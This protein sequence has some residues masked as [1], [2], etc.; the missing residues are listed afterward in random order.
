MT[1]KAIAPIALITALLIFGMKNESDLKGNE[2][3]E[4]VLMKLIVQGL[5]SSH[6]VD[7]KL[8]DSFSGQVYDLYLERMDFNKRFLLAEDIALFEKQRNLIDD[9]INA[10]TYAFFDLSSERIAKRVLEAE[11]YY[12]D[13]LSKPFDFSKDEQFE[14]DAEK[15]GWAVDKKEMKERWRQ[16]LK[17][18]TMTTLASLIEEQEKA[19]EKASEKG[20]KFVEK[21]FKELEKEAREKTAKN[22]DSWFKRLE[23]VT[24]TD[25]RTIFLNTITNVYDPHTSYLPPND[26]E[27]FDI[28]MSGRLEG[29]GATLQEK[30]GYIKVTA[31]VPGSA[32]WRQGELKEDD[33][34]LKVAQGQDEPV[35]IVDMPLDEAVQLIRGKKGTE[36]RLTVKKVSGDI[37]VIP[38]IRDIVILEETYAKSVFIQQEGGAK[39]IGYIKLPKFYADFSKNGGRNCSD[40]VKDELTKLMANDVHG[41]IID[42]RNNGGGSLDDVVKMTGLFIDQGP[43]VQVKGRFGKPYVLED[44][45]KGVYYDGPLVILVNSFSASASE[46]M[47]A[48]IQDYDR[49]IVMGSASTF[50]KGTV[51]RFVDLDRMIRDGFDEIKPLG[52]IKMTTQKFYRIDGGAT[53]NKGVIPDIIMPD[54]YR[55]IE[56]GEKEQDYALPWDEIEAVP[57]KNWQASGFDKN[58]V[59]LSGQQRVDDNEIFDVINNYAQNLKSQRD[60]TSYS[61]NLEQYRKEQ[62]QLKE[63]SEAYKKHFENVL[64]V[65]IT[66]LPQDEMGM[67]SDTLKQELAKKWHEGLK[68]DVYLFE[69]LKVMD[70]M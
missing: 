53:Q 55:Y 3:K 58:Q 34:I 61:L 56:T 35:D 12:E 62:K 45:E 44:N 26:K 66:S 33:V 18:S 36:V 49:G 67:Q 19:G 23:K 54:N 51:Q 42:L 50:G 29:I 69:A 65:G 43:I 8:D 39:K 4:E 25:R 41:V 47:A 64:P 10:G 21:T 46:I 2:N 16:Y 20:E 32:S 11:D 68:K 1:L 40:D 17:Y 38:I 5:S 14:T 6:F 31:I 24:Q 7:M 27:N 37:V 30:D 28:N 52:V 59:A 15:M 60:L 9:Q 22:H 13:I 63:A 57:Y 70:Q 48:A